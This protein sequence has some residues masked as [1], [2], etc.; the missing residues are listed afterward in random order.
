MY[1]LKTRP[2]TFLLVEEETKAQNFANVSYTNLRDEW[3]TTKCDIVL[4]FC[5]IAA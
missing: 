5:C 3:A 4:V 1:T 2:K